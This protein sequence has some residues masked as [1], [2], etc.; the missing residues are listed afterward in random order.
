MIW[1]LSSRRNGDDSFHIRL[2]LGLARSFITSTRFILDKSLA[3]AMQMRG[4]YILERLGERDGRP[5]RD[6]R[7]PIR[8]LFS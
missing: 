7:L 3:K 1:R 2:G 4:C 8:E 5:D 6:F